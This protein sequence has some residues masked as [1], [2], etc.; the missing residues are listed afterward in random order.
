MNSLLL[1]KNEAQK[2]ML[3]TVEDVFG[4]GMLYSLNYTCDYRL[5]D[6]LKFDIADPIALIGA[7]TKL[8]DLNPI[9]QSLMPGLGCSAFLAHDSNGHILL[10]RNYDIKHEMTALLMRSAAQK[11]SIPSL[12]LA[13]MG[14]FGYQK[15]DLN[16][17]KHDNSLC[18]A[19]PYL[20]V[21]GMNEKGLAICVLQ[22]MGCTTHQDTGKKKSITTLAIRNVLDKAGNVEEA[23]EIFRS[24]DMVS[25]REGFDYHF[26]LADPSGRSAVVEYKDDEMHVID[27]DR[28]TNFFLCDP[29]GILQVGRERYDAIDGILRY[30]EGR[31]EKE[32]VLEVLKL[33]SQ[34]SGGTKGRSNTRWS[35]I[36]DLTDLS[37]DIYVDH[38]YQRPYHISMKEDIE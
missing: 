19:A 28:V 4:D 1:I 11:D 7:V 25:T 20:P 2:Q 6:M 37:I 15:G 16:D 27:A 21:E 9:P 10:G 8:M 35:A 26:F 13:D 33:V 29:N 5:D 22:L 38:Q 36:Y 3:N 30:R 18:I 24:R 14:W 23:I 31:L 32:E 17:G 34:P 12:S